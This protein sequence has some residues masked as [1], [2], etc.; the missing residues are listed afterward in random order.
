MTTPALSLPPLRQQSEAFLEE[1]PLSVPGRRVVAG[2]LRRA[3]LVMLVVIAGTGAMFAWLDRSPAVYRGEA[4]VLIEP[5]NTQVSDLQAISAD[6]GNVNLM[7]TQIDILRS[8]AV[9]RRVAEQLGLADDPDFALG[10]NYLALLKSWVGTTLGLIP[11][12][13]LEPGA[14]DRLTA[15]AAALSSR[16]GV[17]NEL[18]SHV[19]TIWIETRSPEL[20]AR[21]ANALAHEL[22]EFRRGQKTAAMARAHT[23]FNARL[24]ELAE[25]TRASD[26]AIE[27]YRIEHGLT[28]LI[29]AAAGVARPQTVNRQQLDDVSSQLTAAEADRQRREGQLAVAE[30]A[31]RRD[32]RADALPEVLNSPII[33]SLREQEAAVAAREAQLSARLGTQA[34]DLVAARSERAGLQRRLRDEMANTLS[35]LRSEVAA[36]RAQEAS[37]RE[38]LAALR[39]A[40]RQDNIAEVRLQSLQSEA[41]ANRAVYQS[42]LARATQLANASGIQEA[43]AELVSE[44]IPNP[45]PSGPL[46]GRLLALAAAAS[47]VLGVVLALLLERLREGF[48]TPDALERALGISSIGVL[49]KLSERARRGG[50]SSAAAEYAASVARL[51]GVMHVLGGSTRAR[52]VTVTSALP[53][54]GKSALALSLSRSAARGGTRVLLVDADMR[55]PFVAREL[56]LGTRPGLAEI[57]AGNLVGDGKEVVH[58]AEPG[59]FVLPAGTLKGDAQEM[60]ASPRFKQ[61]LEWAAGNYDLVVVDTPPVLP[62]TDALLVARV[63]DATLFAVR[64]ES[65]PRA[66]ARD[67]LRLLNGSGA[68][69]LGAVLTQVKLRHFARQANDGLAYLFRDHRAHYGHPQ[70]GK[71]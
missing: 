62:A 64:W 9:A 37:L 25:R 5:R 14:A 52:V 3:W 31:L 35:G 17:Q 13:S 39:S 15:T 32:G 36:A 23:W 10:P 71:A 1:E 33:R 60:L 20:S 41:D 48:S 59:L 27:A 42:F 21:I 51:R 69:V 46:R 30:A 65:T 34:P 12:G 53:R 40:V 58:E 61:L 43:D 7:R 4:S 56:G 29:G 28:E 70:D 18:R 11:P 44:A 45:V 16:I 47:L 49:P 8:P 63:A 66:A 67:A 55:R 50:R 22:L 68:S 6:S 19:L 38:R 54:E 57:L 26:R 2:L 24:E